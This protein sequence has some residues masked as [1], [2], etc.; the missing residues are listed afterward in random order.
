MLP[1][2]EQAYNKLLSMIDSEYFQYN[3]YYSETRLSKE[4]NISRT[5]LRD[6]LNKL[7]QEG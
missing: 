4:F 3:V 7:S 6:A 2:N 1:L 5:P